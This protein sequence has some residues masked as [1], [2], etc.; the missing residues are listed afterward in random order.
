VGG[1]CRLCGMAPAHGDP[2]LVARKKVDPAQLALELDEAQTRRE[3]LAGQLEL[4][5]Y[6]RPISKAP[7]SV[8]AIEMPDELGEVG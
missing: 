4:E 3:L 6:S 1:R 8:P 2:H 7:E 5:W